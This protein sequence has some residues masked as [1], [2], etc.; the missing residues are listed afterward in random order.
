VARDL[1]GGAVVTG[2]YLDARRVGRVTG[3]RIAPLLG[4]GRY[5]TREMLMRELVREYYGLPAEF[6]GS[7]QTRWGQEHE[8]E[9]LRDLERVLEEPLHSG[10]QFVIHPR[11]DFM[12]YTPDARIG[13]EGLAEVKCPWAAKYTHISD[14]PDHFEQV[15]FG[16]EVL[17]LEWAIHA[18]WRPGFG[19]GAPNSLDRSTVLRDPDWL[20]TRLPKIEAFIEE[21][22]AIIESEELSA[23]HLAPLV[24]Q[25][26]DAGWLAAAAQFKDAIGDHGISAAALELA[27]KRLVVL[28]GGRS[29]SGAGVRVHHGTRKGAVEWPKMHRKHIPEVDP[30]EF[31]KPSST[32]ITVALIKG[33]PHEEEDA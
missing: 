13:F 10:G 5:Q 9:A 6:E 18:V 7:P 19:P 1:H 31:R 21:F 26:V 29:C 3:S 14:R 17:D 11:Y 20:A 32:V 27:R 33:N 16:L 25:R 4:L 2:I 23:P 28:S 8:A 22:Q 12:G 24:D 30:E 15:Q